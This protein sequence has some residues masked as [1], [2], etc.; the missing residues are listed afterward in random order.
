M[1][2]S[3]KKTSIRTKKTDFRV[4]RFA[5]SLKKKNNNNNK[6]D[7][8]KAKTKKRRELKKNR[9]SSHEETALV[10]S[11]LTERKFPL[12]FTNVLQEYCF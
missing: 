10:M 5:I 9:K 4:S 7:N 3:M 12:P 2:E 8:S 11:C 6:N 1:E